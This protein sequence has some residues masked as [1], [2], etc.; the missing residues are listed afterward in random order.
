MD[1]A[2]GHMLKMAPIPNDIRRNDSGNT[3]HVQSFRI[4]GR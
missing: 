4:V 3:T 2:L 1:H